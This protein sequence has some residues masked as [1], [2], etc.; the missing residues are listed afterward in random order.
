[1]HT[2]T[3]DQTATSTAADTAREHVLRELLEG[4]RRHLSLE[5][6]GRIREARAHATERPLGGQDSVDLADSD[7]QDELRLSLIQMKAETLNRIDEAL[8]RL[9]EGR[10]GMCRDCGSPISRG[11]LAALPFSI[12]C[13]GCQ[14]RYESAHRLSADADRPM[15]MAF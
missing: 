5:V 6:H 8:H 11:R 13:T 10:Y 2:D 12:R 3:P 14:G 15:A 9:D 7:L 1:M 4:R